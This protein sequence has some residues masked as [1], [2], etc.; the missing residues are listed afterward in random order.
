LKQQEEVKKKRNAINDAAKWGKKPFGKGKVV[1]GGGKQLQ[2]DHCKKPTHH[3][4]EK[5]DNREKTL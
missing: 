3:R 2:K 1:F 5:H 4:K